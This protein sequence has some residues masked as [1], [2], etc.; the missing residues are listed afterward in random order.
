MRRIGKGQEDKAM[1]PRRNHLPQRPT[2]RSSG[3]GVTFWLRGKAFPPRRLARALGLK[4][5]VM[6]EENT[7][8]IEGSKM[9]AI[10][11][12]FIGIGF[13]IAGAFIIVKG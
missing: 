5:E 1:R 4:E 11:I 12:L 6:A 13:V 3:R 8:V 10:Q 9:K 7:L 2:V